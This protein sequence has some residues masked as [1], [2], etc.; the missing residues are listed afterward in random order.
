[1]SAVV[2]ARA[3]GLLPCAQCGLLCRAAQDAGDLSCPRCGGTLHARKPDSLSRTWAFLIASVI[4]YIPAN[5]L[6]VMRTDSLFGREDHTIL[7][8][9][10]DL[11]NGGSWDL[12]VIVFVASIVV[13]ILKMLALALLAI[14]VQRRSRWRQHDRARLYRMLEAVGHWSMLD[15]FVV[16]LLVGLVRFHSIAEVLPGPG[17]AAFGAVV[18]L[19]M[20]SSMSLDPRLIWDTDDADHV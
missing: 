1:M 20:L 7:G 9:V 10:V 4:L 14:S 13:P 5:T 12:A 19:T 17:I 15:V 6:T 8:G 16:A 18:V 3:L 11:W 2:T